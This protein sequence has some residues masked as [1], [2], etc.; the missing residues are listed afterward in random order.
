MTSSE[1]GKI[2]RRRKLYSL[3]QQ[4]LPSADPLTKGHLLSWDTFAKHELAFNCKCLAIREH[5]QIADS[6]QVNHKLSVHYLA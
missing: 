4:N 6:R 2:M 1:K 5:P 3:L